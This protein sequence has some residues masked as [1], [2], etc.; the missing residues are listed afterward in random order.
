VT[1]P[2]VSPARLGMCSRLAV[3]SWCGDGTPPENGRSASAAVERAV[4]RQSVQ[5]VLRVQCER[6]GCAIGAARA[7]GVGGRQ[8]GKEKVYGSIP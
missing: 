6:P 3:R 8:N 2:G 4:D 1:T 7:A 5:R